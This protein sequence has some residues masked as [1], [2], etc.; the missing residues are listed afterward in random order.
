LAGTYDLTKDQDR[1][2]FIATVVGRMKAANRLRPATEVVIV[3]LTEFPNGLVP[4]A[5]RLAIG[6]E[7]FQSFERMVGDESPELVRA[8]KDAR[9]NYPGGLPVVLVY[10]G[11]N[12]V[13]TFF[14]VKTEA[15]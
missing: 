1:A 11:G 7:T 9:N 12:V 14:E 6:Q 4:M 13:G 8:A 15:N 3:N 5:A 10:D 2:D